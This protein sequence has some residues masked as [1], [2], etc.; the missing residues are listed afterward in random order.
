MVQLWKPQYIKG[1]TAA[2]GA[3]GS[4]AL[5]G[6]QSGQTRRFRNPLAVS[7]KSSVETQQLIGAK[8]PVSQ[9]KTMTRTRRVKRKAKKE[10]VA[11]VGAVKRMLR[12]TS[13]MKQQA[14]A[15]ATNLSR[16]IMY[17]FNVTAQVLQGTTDPSRIGDAITLERITGYTTV[18]SATPAAYYQFRFLVIYSGEEYNPS[19]NNYSA[20]GVQGAEVMTLGASG[21]TTAIP[22]LKACTVLHDQLITINSQLDSVEDGATHYFD[23]NLRGFQQKYQGLGSVYGKVK[24]LY[25]ILS[26][27]CSD[28]SIANP[29]GNAYTNYK[30]QF[31]D[32]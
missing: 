19:T 12:A 31:R 10:K 22:N 32:N 11:T 16:N 17:S 8:N 9:T 6:M 4:L 18:V 3:V 20:S 21:W 26:A 23:V 27:D 15:P 1:G 13:E 5:I 2:V 7:M 28:A 29:I 25:L 24:N 14:L 30:L